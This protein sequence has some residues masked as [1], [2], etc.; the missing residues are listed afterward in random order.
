MRISDWSSDVCSS[1]LPNRQPRPQGRAAESWRDEAVDG[2]ADPSLQALHRGFPRPRGR[3]LCGDRKSEGRIRR[4]SGQRRHQQAVPLQD[5]PD[6]VF[7]SAS[8]GH[9]VEGPHACGYDRDHR[10]DRCGVWGVRPVSGLQSY[11]NW[12]QGYGP[13]VALRWMT[14]SWA[15]LVA[16]LWAWDF[17]I[18][19]AHV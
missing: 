4:L 7:A 9:D 3:S 16:A 14:L 13:K 10:R 18:G 1:D 2:I 5:P 12:L 11:R 19:R 17:Q 6:G 8:D 15:I